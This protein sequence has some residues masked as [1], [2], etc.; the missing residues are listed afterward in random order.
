[1][2]VVLLFLSLVALI[3]LFYAVFR[4]A[5]APQPAPPARPAPRFQGRRIERA[6]RAPARPARGKS[7]MRNGRTVTPVRNG[8]RV[9]PDNAIGLGCLAPISECTLGDRCICLNRREFH[10]GGL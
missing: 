3:W 9:I 5:D 8:R 4:H 2:T 6:P 10:G 7:R 1:M